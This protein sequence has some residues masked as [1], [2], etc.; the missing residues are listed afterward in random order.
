M[1]VEE[2]WEILDLPSCGHVFEDS[3]HVKTMDENGRL[4]KPEIAIVRWG[5]A[6]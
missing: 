5:E 1:A 6:S 3:R 4:Q 2:L